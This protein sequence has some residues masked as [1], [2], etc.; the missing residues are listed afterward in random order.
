[1]Q[2]C[3]YHKYYLKNIILK[4]KLV[5]MKDKKKIIDEI[6]K[7]LEKLNTHKIFVQKSLSKKR[8]N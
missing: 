4:I 2:G 3:T 8:I 5:Y 1:M 7:P 6:N